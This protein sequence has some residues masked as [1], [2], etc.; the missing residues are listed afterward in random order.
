MSLVADIHLLRDRVLADLN[1]SHDYYNE[2]AFVWRTIQDLIGSGT[3]FTIQNTATGTISTQIEVAHKSMGY[4]SGQLTE[5][6]FQ[7]FISIF[8]SFIFDLLGLWLTAFPRS[9]IGKKV[10]FKAFL[11]S[12]SSSVQQ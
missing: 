12:D 8:E 10:D 6:T 11:L 3:A 1:S 5:A 4:V 2:S 7:Q 9:L